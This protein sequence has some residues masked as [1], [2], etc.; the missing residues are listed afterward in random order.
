MNRIMKVT[1]SLIAVTNANNYHQRFDVNGQIGLLENPTAA[2]L[3]NEELSSKGGDSQQIEETFLLQVYCNS[4]DDISAAV[5]MGAKL[6]EIP[7]DVYRMIVEDSAIRGH[8]DNPGKPGRNGDDILREI[9][10]KH[11]TMSLNDT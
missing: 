5:K 8:L 2:Y 10:T 9:E 3:Q 11:K 7:D 1:D 6:I 4:L